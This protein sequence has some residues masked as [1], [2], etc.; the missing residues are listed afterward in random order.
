VKNKTQI[1]LA[2]ATMLNKKRAEVSAVTALF[3]MMVMNTL[4][5]E[6]EVNISGFGRFKLVVTRGRRAKTERLTKGT[7]KKGETKGEH[8]VAVEKKYTVHFK[9]AVP[10]RER[11]HRRNGKA[12]IVG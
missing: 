9:K 6:G 7:F 10:F 3:C 1:D 4:V 5:E 8:L 12:P 2:V 11:L